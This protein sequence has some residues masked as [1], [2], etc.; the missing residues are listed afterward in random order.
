[1][2]PSHRT[3]PHV[4]LDSFGL[5]HYTRT[6]FFAEL[7]KRS[8]PVVRERAWDTRPLTL[9]PDMMPPDGQLM[10]R[11]DN[12]EEPGLLYRTAE[13]A[14]GEVQLNTGSRVT[15]VIFK[16]AAH[17]EEQIDREEQRLREL[18]PE[19]LPSKEEVQIRFWTYSDGAARCA[20]RALRMDPFD[21]LSDNYGQTVCSELKRLIEPNFD[22][23]DRGRL[24]LWHGPAGTGKTHAVRS[25]IRSWQPW[26]QAHYVTDPEALFS[27]ASYLMAVLSHNKMSVEKWNLLVVEDAGELMSADAKSRSGQGLSRL[28]NVTDG[29]L[30]Q[31]LRLMVLIT[32][33]ETLGDLH[34]AVSRPGRC[35]SLLEVGPLSADEAE[36]WLEQHAPEAELPGREVTLAELYALK[37]GDENT[38]K[39]LRRRRTTIGFQ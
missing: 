14:L 11:R 26:C 30:G 5:N 32:T 31:G 23:Q 24:L 38:I 21:R 7:G 3:E 19:Q 15:R 4:V 33:N 34:P 8:F 37:A 16:M 22:P 18:F 29:L 2:A 27:N 17:D 13:G 25:L 1:M 28:L 6:C 12:N 10:F 36:Q 35:L 9:T 39:E 20:D